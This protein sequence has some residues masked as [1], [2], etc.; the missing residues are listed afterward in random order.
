[1]KYKLVVPKNVKHIALPYVRQVPKAKQVPK[2]TLVPTE[3]PVPTKIH[4][5]TCSQA[6]KAPFAPIE[7]L[8]PEERVQHQVFD[9]V[10]DVNEIRTISV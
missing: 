10:P 4:V 6:I 2:E 9:T 3:K 8:T 7:C 1:M 5:A